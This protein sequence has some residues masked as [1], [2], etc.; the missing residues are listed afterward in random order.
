M[1]IE[2]GASGTYPGCTKVLIPVDN[3]AAI[4]VGDE[5][6]ATTIQLRTGQQIGTFD[7]HGRPIRDDAVR[8]PGR[9]R[10]LAA[11]TM[12]RIGATVPLKDA[13]VS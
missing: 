5:N 10:F 1:F 9:D 7:D 12:G 4:Y 8:H 6:V 2:I 13:S 3:I 11:T